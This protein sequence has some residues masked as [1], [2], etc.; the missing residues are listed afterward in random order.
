M[1]LSIKTS[2][3]VSENTRFLPKSLK[4][5][6]WWLE[7]ELMSEEQYWKQQPT[8]YEVRARSAKN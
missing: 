4:R 7:D 5:E 2:S 8:Y 1:K 6:G 3:N